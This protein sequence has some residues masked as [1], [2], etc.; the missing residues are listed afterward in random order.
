MTLLE[1]TYE[2]QSPLSLQQLSRLGEFANTYGLRKFRVNEQKNQVTFEY[3]ASR[4]R[5]TQ[6]AHVLGQAGIAIARKVN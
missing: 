5:D 3:D 2:L 4:L 1:I 6:V